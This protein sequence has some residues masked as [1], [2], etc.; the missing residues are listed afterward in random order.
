MYM[1]KKLKYNIN[2]KCVGVYDWCWWVLIKEVFVLSMSWG[3]F[4]AA[5]E[6]ICECYINSDRCWLTEFIL[7]THNCNVKWVFYSTLC[8]PLYICHCIYVNR[9]LSPFCV[10]LYYHSLLAGSVF[11]VQTHCLTSNTRG[12]FSPGLQQPHS[13]MQLLQKKVKITLGPS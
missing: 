5:V 2:I 3:V 8:L 12:D 10:H 13:E 7:F 9:Y 6:S 4:A 1:Q 11:C